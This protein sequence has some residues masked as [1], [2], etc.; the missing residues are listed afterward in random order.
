MN[1]DQYIYDLLNRNDN[2][3]W[4]IWSWLI[5]GVAL[6]FG[7]PIA[8]VCGTVLSFAA[9]DVYGFHHVGTR[10]ETKN[11][12]N[13]PHFKELILSYRFMQADKKIMFLFIF[14]LVSVIHSFS[15]W[16]TIAA[17]FAWWM[18]FCDLLYYII[19]RQWDMLKFKD[20]MNW[21]E[22]TLWG[23]LFKVFKRSIHGKHLVWFS[24]I[25]FLLSMT[26]II[27]SHYV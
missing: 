19:L 26:M 13:E 7:E 8:L 12:D 21:L 20:H 3:L 14:I 10:F 25:G 18:G 1:K 2:W 23:M 9:F 15:A 24:S 4:L 16:I 27:W 22:W 6:V 11:E 5:I 17:V